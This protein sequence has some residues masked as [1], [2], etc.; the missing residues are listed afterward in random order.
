[1][2]VSPGALTV[3][4]TQCLIELRHLWMVPACGLGLVTT[5]GQKDE[6]QIREADDEKKELRT[7]GGSQV[8]LDREIPNKK[9]KSYKKNGEDVY[10]A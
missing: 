9:H 7:F 10:F 8:N 3:S 1:M 6:S 4:L 2:H 5:G